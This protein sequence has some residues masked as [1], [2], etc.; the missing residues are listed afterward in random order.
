MWLTLGIVLLSSSLVVDTVA[1][2]TVSVSV[3]SP[4]ANP[5]KPAVA[6]AEVAYLQQGERVRLDTHRPL[7]P[8]P[9]VS[10]TDHRPFLAH[11]A[12]SLVAA[13]SLDTRPHG[14]ETLASFGEPGV[15]TVSGAWS[16]WTAATYVPGWSS[17]HGHTSVVHDGRMW[18][19]GGY[20]GSYLNDVWSSSDGIGWTLVTSAAAWSGRSLH[21]S[22]VHDG[23]MWVM[24]GYDESNL[25]D[26]WSSSN[27]VTWTRVTSAA[28]WTARRLHASVVYDGRMWVM[29]GAWAQDVWSSSDGV[30][31]TEAGNYADWSTRFHLTC[32]VY[33]GR[34][35][36]MGGAGF[37]GFMNNDVWSSTDGAI[38][39]KAT[40]YAAWRGRYGHVSVVHD[41]RMWV[42]GGKDSN[43]AYLDD[44]WSSTDG[45]TWTQA[46]SADW[47]PCYFPTSVVYDGRMWVMGGYRGSSL[48]SV[49]MS[50]LATSVPTS[51]PSTFT[52]RPSTQPS[53][54]PSL[55]PSGQPSG[56]PSQPSGQPSGEPSQPSGAPSSQPSEQP[57]SQP[58]GEPTSLPSVIC[59]AGSFH[60]LGVATDPTEPCEL[61]PGGTYSD[62]AAA[63][64]CTPCAGISYSANGAASAAECDLT[65]LQVGVWQLVGLFS[66]IIM[67]EL[68][69]FLCN[70]PR[71][72]V[73]T[74]GFL[75]FFS[76]FDLLSDLLFLLTTVFFSRALFV[77]CFTVFLLPSLHFGWV[78]YH[79]IKSVASGPHWYRVWFPFIGVSM[80]GGYLHFLGKRVFCF[81]DIGGE[82]PRFVLYVLTFPLCGVAQIC[83]SIAWVCTHAVMYPLL[84]VMGYFLYTTQLSQ[85]HKM[86][87]MWFRLILSEESF[88]NLAADIPSDEELDIGGSNQAVIGE[89]LLES[90]PQ[91]CLV[92]ING[93]LMNELTTVDYISMSG[94]ALIIAN[95]LFK[96]G[97]WR[98]WMGV[99]LRHIPHSGRPDKVHVK[100]CSDWKTSADDFISHKGGNRKAVH[101]VIPMSGVQGASSD[102]D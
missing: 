85:T 10:S 41:G 97:Y 63:T 84:F 18:V 14:E 78:T 80:P 81:E 22:V 101:P 57:T 53:G 30:T 77:A 7:P 82:G 31:W 89:M 98:L 71:E 19:M 21:S 70:R 72:N 50:T 25:N 76:S 11:A 3:P 93:N 86:S 74:L 51:Q 46:I 95:S 17:R 96:F 6:A 60:P 29:G 37:L 26:V 1:F 99:P 36:V 83:L 73:R 28:A 24:G 94:S 68:V 9:S 61:C 91:A 79:K 69:V 4:P 58:S 23:R 88:S 48:R 40:S 33:D 38:W 45:V 56:E 49:W 35:W 92:L 90:I 12:S 54:A 32:V 44:V 52:G 62:T 87:K 47:S 66:V 13:P 39:T 55:P 42:M 15:A 65:T 59:P 20:D 16:G 102:N 43:D 5:H 34:M 27:G 100:E 8:Q 67:A 2:S 75:V 64:S